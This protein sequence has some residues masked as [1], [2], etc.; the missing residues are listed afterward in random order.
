MN[1][2]KIYNKIVERG[3]NRATMPGELYERHHIVPRC[4]GGSDEMD[5]ITNLT[6][7]EHFLAHWLLTKIHTDNRKLVYAFLCMVRD[8]HGNRAVKSR[9]YEKIKKAV[10]IEQRK[11]FLVEN[12]MWTENARLMHSQRMKRSNPQ[13]THP[14]KCRRFEES[15]TKNKVAYNNGVK[16]K[17]FLRDQQPEGWVLGLLPYKRNWNGGRRRHEG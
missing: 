10:S 7:R 15:P 2:K 11:H 17:Y 9:Y 4:L 5:N 6:C 3:K 16:N 14:E 1:Y 8:P 13:H 12:P